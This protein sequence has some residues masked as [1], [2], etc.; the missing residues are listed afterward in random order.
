MLNGGCVRDPLLSP[1]RETKDWDVEIYGVEP[2]RLL[3]IIAE[4]GEVNIA[5]EAFAVYKVGRHLDVSLPRRERKSGVGHRAFIVEGDPWMSFE[6]A[7][8]RRDFTINAILEDPLTGEIIDPFDGR[9]DIEQIG[10]AHV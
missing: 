10:R 3:S 9:S 2:D 4:F 5:G 7:C 8:R 6:D 1:R